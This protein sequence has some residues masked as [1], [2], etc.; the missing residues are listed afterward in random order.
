MKKDTDNWAEVEATSRAA[1][2]DSIL[3]YIEA[4]KGDPE[5]KS[6]LI[7][8]LH[9]VQGH[10]GF[11]GEE[12][13]NAVAQLMQIPTADVTGVATFYHFFRLEPQG[14]FMIRVC[15]GTACYVKGA[16]DILEK[17]QKELGI[18]VGETSKDGLFSLEVSRCLGTCGL[19]PVVMVGD[20][21][22]GGL[23]PDQ[24]PALLEEYIGK[25]HEAESVAS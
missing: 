10:F 22:H 20:E 15:M 1:L 11:L 5:F 13:L 18:D 7:S 4:C 2:P 3:D 14:R 12:Q 23:T 25:A 16:N 8:V 6:Q 24:V 19:A 17:L 21:I 9:K